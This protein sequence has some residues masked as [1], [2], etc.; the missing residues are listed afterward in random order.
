MRILR[1]VVPRTLERGWK[2]LRHGLIAAGVDPRGLSIDAAI[3]LARV[4]AARKRAGLASLTTAAWLASRGYDVAK[5]TADDAQ[6]IVSAWADNGWSRP[7]VVQRGTAR[8][9]LDAEREAFDNE[10][11]PRGV[12]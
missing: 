9:G 1:V 6:T 11:P 12:A 5:L 8:Q 7:R 3:A 10:P 2:G 4:L